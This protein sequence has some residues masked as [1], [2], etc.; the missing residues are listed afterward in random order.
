MP[1]SLLTR[2]WFT[3]CRL[4]L[5]R[6]AHIHSSPAFADAE[7]GDAFATARIF[8]ECPQSQ[9]IDSVVEYF[10]VPSRVKFAEN[11]PQ[12]KDELHCLARGQVLHRADADD[13]L[14]RSLHRFRFHFTQYL[15]QQDTKVLAQ[16]VPHRIAEWIFF[17]A[18]KPECFFRV[19]LQCTP[20]PAIQ[21]PL[22][23]IRENRAAGELTS[24]RL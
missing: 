22:Q 23:I 3:W 17:R 16:G 7:I 14:Q 12:L 15:F 24:N 20:Q 1:E 19:A 5:S 8:L 10:V 18:E 4:A 21:N 2:R 9:L 13:V 6:A 11:W